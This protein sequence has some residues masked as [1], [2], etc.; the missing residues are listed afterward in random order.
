V[1]P[2]QIIS[3]GG[4][5]S[6]DPANSRFATWTK[7]IIMYCDGAQHQGHNDDPIAYKDALLYF[8]GADNTRSHLK[9]L[10]QKYQI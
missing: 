4:Y 6:T 1:L 10:Q 9:W 2:P 8:R 5:L 7:V 3:P